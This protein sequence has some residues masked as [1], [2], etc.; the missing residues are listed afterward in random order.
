MRVSEAM[1]RTVCMA[2]PDQTV[3][4]IARLMCDADIGCMP[5]RDDDRLVGMITD[6]DIAVR[7]IGCGKGPETRVRDVMTAEVK[8]C[9]EDQDLDDVADNMGEQQ[10]RRMPVLDRS[11]RLVGVLALGD[12]A[13]V[14]G[15]GA[16]GEAL[17][18][19]SRPGGDHSQSSD[20]AIH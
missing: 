10:V 11:K 2:Y 4:E 20:S 1:T 6:R 12:V 15:N 7:A 8:Y 19:I 18:Q 5:V 9:F 17:S 14:D 16:A 3:E 13:L